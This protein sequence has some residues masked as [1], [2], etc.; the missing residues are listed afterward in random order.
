MRPG[1]IEDIL[2]QDDLIA[3]GSA[4]RSALDRNRLASMILWGPPGS[5]KTTLARLVARS[6]GLRFVAFSA[7]LSGIKEVKE[8]MAAAE[9]EHRADGRPTLLFIDEIH[10]FNRAQQDA[11]L[12]HVE[13]GTILLIGA[14]TENPSFA[15]NAA[16]LSRCAVQVLKALSEEHLVSLLRRALNDPRGLQEQNLAIADAELRLMAARA[17]GDAR[18]ALNALEAVSMIV[19]GRIGASEGTVTSPVSRQDVD[20]ALARATLLYDK[21]GEEHFNL[22]SALHKSLRNSDADAAL[23]WLARMLESGEDPLYVARRMIRFAS[24]DV[25][26]AD[27]GALRVALSARDAFVSLG[28]PEGALA[29]AQAAIYLAATPKS[30]SVYEAYGRVLE[31]LRR[32]GAAPVPLALRNAPTAL[33][34]DL[35][36]GR[37]DAYA[38]DEPEGTADLECLPERLRGRRFYQP[39]FI[40]HERALGERLQEMEN[41]RAKKAAGATKPSPRSARTDE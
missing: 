1:T 23:Y 38:H 31:E 10:R 33:M 7:V 19:A 39:N 27:P 24:E 13:Q 8:V 2:G 26:N 18:R 4:L 21:A 15:V 9:R 36:Y 40:G 16:L 25:G 35:G 20:R 11:F 5:G 37:D 17:G 3:P 34:R 22:I 41:R 30:N 28:M 14:T 29:L 6:A 12:P 32:G